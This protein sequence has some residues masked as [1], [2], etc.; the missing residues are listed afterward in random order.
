MTDH[1]PDT[2]EL[3]FETIIAIPTLII[4]AYLIAGGIKEELRR[5]FK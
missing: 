4:T 1:T 2:I 5:Y 3:I